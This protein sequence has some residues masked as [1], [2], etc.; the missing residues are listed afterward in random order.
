M[1]EATEIPKIDPVC[2]TN[3]DLCTRCGTCAGI[4]PE[5]CFIFN[6]EDYPKIVFSMRR[7]WSLH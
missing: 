6:E 3:K 1:K 5:D 4:C 7:M 2:E